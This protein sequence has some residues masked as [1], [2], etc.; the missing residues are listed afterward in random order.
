MKKFTILLVLL[1]ASLSIGSAQVQKRVTISSAPDF[2]SASNLANL[3]NL[4]SSPVLSSNLPLV[5]NSNMGAKIPTLPSYLTTAELV[6]KVYSAPLDDSGWIIASKIPGRFA[7]LGGGFCQMPNQPLTI[8]NA[9]HQIYGFAQFFKNNDPERN[10]KLTIDTVLLRPYQYPFGGEAAPPVTQSVLLFGYA[11][12]ADLQNGKATSWNFSLNNPSLRLLGD[13]IEIPADVINSRTLLGPDNRISDILNTVIEVPNWTVEADESFGFV[14]YVQNNTDQL[15]LWATYLRDEIEPDSTKTLG[16]FAHRNTQTDEEFL[17][18]QSFYGYY[19][20]S[21]SFKLDF[22][23]LVNRALKSNF[24]C[25]VGGNLETSS[26]VETLSDDAKAFA[27]EPVTPNPVVGATK[28]QFSLQ[29][30]SQVSLRV[31]NSLGQV[32]K[33]LASG[34]MNTGTYSADFDAQDLPTGMYYYTLVAG[35]Q[36]LTRSMVVVK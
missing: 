14:F 13:E 32:V 29:Q 16:Y 17:T 5:S 27:L 31:T 20:P 22:P 3:P 25:V 10:G 23:Q 18:K 9:Q 35:T 12:K 28:I 7:M 26:S 1:C 4:A 36:S 24:L 21:D 34:A 6:R 30:P 8:N 33:E 2:R 19:N 11:V 15:Q